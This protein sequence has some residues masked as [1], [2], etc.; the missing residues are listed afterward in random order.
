M[1]LLPTLK[2][3]KMREILKYVINADAG[4]YFG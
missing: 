2:K 4:F 3:D 1:L